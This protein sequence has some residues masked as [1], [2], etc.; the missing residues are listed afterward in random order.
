MVDLMSKEA[1]MD[2]K[3]IEE[4]ARRYNAL[5]VEIKSL[6]SALKEEKQFLIDSV[7]LG[8]EYV[9]NSVIVK[10]TAVAGGISFDSKK[11]KE[12]YPELFEKYS[13]PKSGYDLLTV[14]C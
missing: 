3:K 7:G 9:G 12:D 8:N 6:Q 1:Y 13:K 2:A 4:S 10:V 11:F 14:R 5:D